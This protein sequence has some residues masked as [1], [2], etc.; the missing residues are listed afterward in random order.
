MTPQQLIDGLHNLAMQA[1]IDAVLFRVPSAPG[2]TDHH[3]RLDVTPRDVLDLLEC[4]A[5]TKHAVSVR[6]EVATDE[7]GQ[8]Y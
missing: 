8:R 4:I 3:M 2:C 5:L 6:E 7:F 1:P